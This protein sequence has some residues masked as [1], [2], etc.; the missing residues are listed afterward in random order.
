MGGLFDIIPSTIPGNIYCN[1]DK[2]EEVL[3]YF[4]VSAV[5][6]KRLF[7]KDKFIGKYQLYDN[8]VTDT[9]YLRIP[10]DTSFLYWGFLIYPDSPYP[11]NLDSIPQESWNSIWWVLNEFRDSI[12]PMRFVT[13]KRWCGDCTAKGINIKPSFW[14]DDK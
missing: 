9:A 7:I 14:D 4:S 3:G 1:E 8:C 12:P 6:S 10:N 2:L 11:L 5:K 13:N